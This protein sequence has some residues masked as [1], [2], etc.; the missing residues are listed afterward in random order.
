MSDFL[1]SSDYSQ[2]RCHHQPWI[3][4]RWCE[5]RNLVYQDAT[6]FFLS[7]ASFQFQ[8]PFIIPGPRTP[9]LDRTDDRLLAEPIVKSNR[10]SQIPHQLTVIDRSVYVT[11]IWQDH[12]VAW[13]TIFDFIIPVYNTMRKVNKTEQPKDRRVYLRSGRIPGFA[14][15]MKAL[16]DEP[17]SVISEG[18]PSL[19]LRNAVL[20]VEKLERD[21]DPHRQTEINNF[22]YHVNR[23]MAVGLRETLL[24]ELQIENVGTVKPLVILLESSPS[25]TNL[26]EIRVIIAEDCAKCRIERVNLKTLNPVE[27]VRLVSGASVLVGRQGTDLGHVIWMAES[28]RTHL[29]EIFPYQYPCRDWYK[30]A[31]R[32]AGV[33]YH[34]VMN[35]HPP[36]EPAPGLSSCWDNEWRRCTSH[37]CHEL[38]QH[39]NVTVEL[40]VFRETWAEV[41]SDGLAED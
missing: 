19:L 35:R 15:W 1:P 34:S 36:S 21:D 27:Q 8:Q 3:S 41:T 9:P 11:G 18:N 31:A 32:V 7:P 29:I 16:S 6:F 13:F 25:I 33:Q 40:D 2:F 38:Q 20:G 5:S 14:D 39:A 10:L 24:R 28:N 37:Q 26:D 17:L 4:R 12:H 30:T 23:S 22:R